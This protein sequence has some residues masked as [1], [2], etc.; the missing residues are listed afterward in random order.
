MAN[1]NTIIVYNADH[2]GLSQLYQMRGRVGRSHHM[3]FAY[4]V[5]QADRILT[6]TAEKRLQAMK[7]FAELGAGFKIA[8][9]D[10]EI[11]GAGNLLGAQQH[12]HIA[13]V[14]FEMYCKLLEE[15][16][17]KLQHGRTEEIQTEQPDP[18]IDLQVEAYLDGGYIADGMHKIEIYQ[19]IAAIRTNEE[20]R[21]LLD[22]LIDRFGDPTKP[23]LHLLEV[24][25]IRNY[26]RSLGIRSIVQLPKAIDLYLLP[27]HK[28]PIR[29]MIA[30]DRMFG[31][32]MKPIAGKNGFRFVLQD[33]YR[34]NVTNFVTRLLMAA[35]GEEQSAAAG[36]Q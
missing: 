15:A 3:A 9:R 6:E 4:F 24:A 8:M 19:R 27:D 11:R 36:S 13:S 12:G 5:Y 29:G 33:R 31:R 26:A 10:L 14:G 2:F 34:Q 21:N 16:V 23:V 32:M 22:E 25:R 1:A 30:L 20:L 7:E 18:V 17:E 28:L 35:A